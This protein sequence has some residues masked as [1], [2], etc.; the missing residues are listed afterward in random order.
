MRRLM[1]ARSAISL[2]MLSQAATLAG[3]NWTGAQQG[4]MEAYKRMEEADRKGDPQLWFTLRDRKTLDSM[5]AKVKESIRK[6]GRSRPAVQYEVH[7]IRALGTRAVLAGKVTDPQGG[8]VQYAA[9]LFGIEDQQWKISREQWSDT[10]FDPFVLSAW[11]PPEDGAFLRAGAPWKRV[12][13]ATPNAQVLGKQEMVWKIQATVDESFVYVRF[14]ANAAVL[15]AGAKLGQQAGKTGTT[16]GLPPP[17]PM[18]IKVVPSGDPPPTDPEYVISV[19]DLVTTHR[20]FDTKGKPDAN[21]YSVAYSLFVKNGAG[22]DIFQSMI[23]EDATSRLLA[24]QGRF[25]DVKLPLSGLGVDGP[26]MP[27]ISMEEADSVFRV[28]PYKVEAFKP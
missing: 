15:Q 3:Q 21:R 8:T 14:E 5:D 2:L 6:G 12:P 1:I 24:V 7:A 4:V 10:P 9:V 19:S 26:G 28:L 17:P 18:R 16:G 13:Y 23:G 25:I 22:E 27:K 20:G 11:M